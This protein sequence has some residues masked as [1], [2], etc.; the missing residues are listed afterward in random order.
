MGSIANLPKQIYTFAWYYQFDGVG[1]TYDL[2]PAPEHVPRGSAVRLFRLFCW[3]D[4]FLTSPP[5]AYFQFGRAKIGQATAT[6]LLNPLLSGPPN[7]VWAAGVGSSCEWVL[8]ELLE[9]GATLY[10]QVVTAA[11]PGSAFSGGAFVQGQIQKG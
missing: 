4:L 9:G 8:S 11:T 10:A 5:E 3:T 1:G 6:A 2:G 7:N